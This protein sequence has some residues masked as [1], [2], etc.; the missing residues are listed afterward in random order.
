MNKVF[1]AAIAVALLAVP[2]V[3]SATIVNIDATTSGCDFN[4]CSGQHNGP[5]VVVDAIYSPTQ[6]TLAAG[7]YTVTNANGLPGSD[8]NFTAWNFN[9]SGDNWLW[10]FMAIVD[11]TRTVLLDSLPDAGITVVSTQA[12]AAAEAAAVNYVGHFTLTQTTTV[13]FVTE[14]YIPQDN[15]GGM[16]L[17]VQLDGATPP[18]VP[19]PASWALMLMGFGGLGAA[20]RGARRR[21]VVAA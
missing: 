6:L 11:S 13:D 2:A 14:D 5:G 10:S 4:H 7:S 1:A 19:E 20:L 8:P 3:A 15:L 12:A 16:S 9:K 21:D 17:N 18:G